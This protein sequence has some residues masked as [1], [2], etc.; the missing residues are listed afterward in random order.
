M[1]KDGEKK[2]NK[3]AWK[4][5]KPASF[6]NNGPKGHSKKGRKHREESAKNGKED[7]Q[8]N[9]QEKPAGASVEDI[10]VRYGSRKGKGKIGPDK[11]QGGGRAKAN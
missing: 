10:P 7:R 5:K 11:R 2:R 3:R 1:K 8:V 4:T 6:P 9:S